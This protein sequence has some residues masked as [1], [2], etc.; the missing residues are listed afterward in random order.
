M[1]L[2]AL[3]D[4]LRAEYSTTVNDGEDDGGG[5]HDGDEEEKD[6][7]GGN[8]GTACTILLQQYTK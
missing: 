2:C 1:L 5:D 3:H 7:D 4:I 6:K 8:D